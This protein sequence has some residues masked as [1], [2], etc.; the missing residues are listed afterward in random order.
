M[1]HSITLQ[2]IRNSL[3]IDPFLE[4]PTNVLFNT[5]PLF[6]T[7]G[8]EVLKK[9]LYAIISS[10]ACDSKSV[11]KDCFRHLLNDFFVVSDVLIN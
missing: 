9:E 7:D 11:T 6:V 8:S 4:N 1:P 10:Q 3:A 5:T 2:S